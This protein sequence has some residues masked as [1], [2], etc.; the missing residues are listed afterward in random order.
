MVRGCSSCGWLVLCETLESCDDPIVPVAGLVDR[1][2]EGAELLFCWLLFCWLLGGWGTLLSCT[3]LFE[4]GRV[5]YDSSP[6]VRLIIVKETTKGAF[7]VTSLQSYQS[8]LTVGGPSLSIYPHTVEHMLST[9]YYN[10]LQVYSLLA[11]PTNHLITQSHIKWPY[12]LE[13]LFQWDYR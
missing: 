7:S 6:R 11:F 2:T 9:T 3:W 5:G 1:L 10:H 8:H 12:F 13:F 4:N